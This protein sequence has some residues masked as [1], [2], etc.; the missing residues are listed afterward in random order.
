MGVQFSLFISTLSGSPS[1]TLNQIQLPQTNS[2]LVA[3][4]AGGAAMAFPLDATRN[5]VIG[6]AVGQPVPSEKWDVN[7][8]IKG[9]TMNV[10]IYWPTTNTS[11]TGI[12]YFGTPVP[13]A[14]KAED[15]AGV[16]QTFTASQSASGT[17]NT[18]LTFSFPAG[19]L[20]LTGLYAGT[21]STNIGYTQLQFTPAA[22]YQLNVFV[23]SA[24]N[25]WDSGNII[26]LEGV[27]AGSTLTVNVTYTTTGSATYNLFVIFY[28]KLM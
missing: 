13:G 19:K 26:P 23:N 11:L 27:L 24:G 12:F 5:A 10:I 1:G 15:L 14:L 25:L 20:Q 4:A 28:Y 22:G 9:S 7:I 21:S 2:T 18:T 8:P 6:G 16:V 3:V 17:F